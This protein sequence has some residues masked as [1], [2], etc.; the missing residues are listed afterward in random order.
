MLYLGFFYVLRHEEN[1]CP[2]KLTSIVKRQK[3]RHLKK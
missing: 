1:N 3:K 2:K